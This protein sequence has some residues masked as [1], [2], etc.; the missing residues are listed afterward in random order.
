MAGKKDV[1]TTRAVAV[2]IPA[3]GWKKGLMLMATYAPT[4]GTT[5]E[6]VEERQ[7]FWENVGALASK[8][9]H[10]TTLT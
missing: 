7:R 6:L 2:G 10:G 3:K 9:Q 1:S 5:L 4:S 8:T